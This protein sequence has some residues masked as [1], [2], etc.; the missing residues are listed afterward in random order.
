MKKN[1]EYLAYMWRH[2]WSV[3]KAGW[4][5]GVPWSLLVLHDLSKFL[6]WEWFPYLN[7]FYGTPDQSSFDRAWLDHIHHNKHHWQYWVLREDNGK[8]VCL[9]MPIYYIL[10]MVADWIGVGQAKG[11]TDPAEVEKWYAANIDK[12]PLSKR[13]RYMVELTI[14]FYVMPPGG[15]N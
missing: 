11:S 1:L 4:K 5:L 6:P 8:V 10:E 3:F 7:Y 2:K 15:E 13:T 12:I 14:Y 9:D